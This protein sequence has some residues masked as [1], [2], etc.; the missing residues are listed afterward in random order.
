MY[1]TCPICGRKTTLTKHHILKW[2][3]FHNDDKENTIYLCAKCH[4]YGKNCLEELIRERENNILRQYPEMYLNALQ[5]Y[6]R[7]VRPNAKPYAKKRR[8]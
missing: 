7:G 8:N 5:D 4:N 2:A 6:M 1:G 3:V